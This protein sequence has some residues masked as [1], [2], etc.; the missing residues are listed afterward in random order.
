M[1]N[2]F[3]AVLLLLLGSVS[4]MGQGANNIRINEVLTSNTSSI[5]DE[6][7]QHRGWVELVNTAY[8]SYNIRGMFITTNRE[9]LNPK[10]SAPQRM[11]LMQ[12]IPSGDSRTALSARQH[13]VFYLGSNPAQGTLHLSVPMDSTTQWIALYDGNAIDLIDSVSIPALKAN[14]SFARVKDGDKEW[15]MKAPEYVT[16][17]ISNFT[18]HAESKIDKLKREDPHGF[19]ITVLS[20]GIVFGCLFILYV[21][22]TIFG[23]ALGHKRAIKKVATSQ[24]LKPIVKPVVVTG[25]KLAEVGH[26]TNV[27]LQDG[28]KS[29]GI[30][31]EIYIAVIAMALKQHLDNVHDTESGIITIKPHNSYWNHMGQ[32]GEAHLVKSE[33]WL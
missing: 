25:S 23:M 31:K 32:S 8:S 1:K 9:A 26:K 33:M 19:G 2:L 3:S 6:F 21:I 15:V 20:M 5:Q 30:D 24:P 14:T 16:P 29:K 11:E 7:G 27:M 10:L 12:V 17:G 4:A 22:F 18:N 28:M 13:I